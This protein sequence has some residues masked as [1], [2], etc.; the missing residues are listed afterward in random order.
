MIDCM[1]KDPTK[2]SKMLRNLEHFTMVLM[3]PNHGSEMPTP[4]R[5]NNHYSLTTINDPKKMAA[6]WW[7]PPGKESSRTSAEVSG[8][9]GL[10][11]P[12]LLS[13]LPSLDTRL[14]R[15]GRNYLGADHSTSVATG[16]LQQA[17][18]YSPL[19]I[20]KTDFCCWLPSASWIVNRGCACHIQ[21]PKID[22]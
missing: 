5:I 2:P 7:P 22:H 21:H 19:H 12:P 10:T 9:L 8:S 11:P 6:A 4:P 20:L 15:L 1:F 13:V 17:G 18:N 16:V 3:G 14:A